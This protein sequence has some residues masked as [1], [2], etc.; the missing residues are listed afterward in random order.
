MEAEAAQVAEDGGSIGTSMVNWVESPH[1]YKLG[2]TLVL[3]VG[4]D[5]TV[6]SLLEGILGPQFAGR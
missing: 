4:E 5:P 2:R 6:K 1:F 3:Y